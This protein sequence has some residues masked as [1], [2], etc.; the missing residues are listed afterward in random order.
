MKAAEAAFKKATTKPIEGGQKVPPIPGMKES[1]TP[2]IDQDLL[3]QPD[4]RG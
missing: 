1:V 3:D 4:G 2:R